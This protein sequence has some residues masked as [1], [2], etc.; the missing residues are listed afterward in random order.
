M[1]VPFVLIYGPTFSVCIAAEFWNN[2]T[3]EAFL[4]GVPDDKMIILDLNSIVGPVWRRT[5]SYFGK[6]FVWC[7]LHN[8]GG[9][10]AI[11]GNLTGITNGPPEALATPGNTM[12]GVGLTPEAIEQN[13]VVYDLMVSGFSLV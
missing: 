5:Q 3:I 13:P 1:C 8:F 11:Y 2:V 4:S 6:P 12:V 9:M 10:R 7:L